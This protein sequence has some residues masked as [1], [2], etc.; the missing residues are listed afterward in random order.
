MNKA[1]CVIIFN[2]EDTILAVT[3]RGR[4]TEF[5]LP[6]GKVDDGESTVEAAVREVFEE[7]GVQLDPN[8]LTMICE[9]DD[10]HG[11]DVTA[12][13]YVKDVDKESA[14]QREEGIDVEWVTPEVLTDGPFGEYN[15]LLF[16]QYC[17]T[18]I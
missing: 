18:L 6:G 15:A 7:T 13:A 10:G 16:V 11:Y 4:P 1:V 8:F 12:F 17:Y 2:A 14:H 5:V 3:R 9:G